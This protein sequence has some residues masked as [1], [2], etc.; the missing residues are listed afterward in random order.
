MSLFFRRPVRRARWITGLLLVTLAAAACGSSETS[1]DPSGPC[2]SDGSAEGAY[3][4]LEALIPGDFRD[5]APSRLDSG[6]NC[7]DEN[8][9]TLAGHGIDEIRFAGGTW[10]FGSDI[11][12]VMAVFTADGLTAEIL[13]EWWETTAQDAS[14]TE[15]TGTTMIEVNDGTTVARRLDTKTGERIQ[16]VISWPSPVEGQ[17]YVVISHNLAETAL[18]L[19]IDALDR[20]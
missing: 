9:G 1:F 16:T 14:R 4:E 11:A 20:R 13:A 2:I 6:R 3:P 18:F 8:L 19:A 17:V 12:L 5:R 7:T 10:D 15:V